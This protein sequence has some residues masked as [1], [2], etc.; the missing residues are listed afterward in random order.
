MQASAVMGYQS[1]RVNT[2]DRL[3]LVVMCYEGC[4]ANA[5]RAMEEMKQGH[6][7][8]KGL[9][10]G[11]AVAI[12]G[13]L[14]AVLDHQKGGEISTRLEALYRYVLDLFT[15]ANLKNDPNRIETG[16]RVLRELKEAWE[17]LS[18]RNTNRAPD[19]REEFPRQQVRG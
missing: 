8:N 13:E 10:L 4:I 9:F 12:V 7:A 15:E 1:A 3:Q 6:V 14:M 2:V 17:T 16:V 19:M 5:C 18:R 11:K